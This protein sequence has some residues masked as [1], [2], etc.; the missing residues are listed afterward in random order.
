MSGKRQAEDLD[1]SS[2]AKKQKLSNGATSNGAPT[3][4]KPRPALPAMEAIAKAKRA[5]ELQKQLK[6][7][8][9]AAK[10]KAPTPKPA[11]TQQAAPPAVRP[12]VPL[13]SLQ[14]GFVPY[15]QPRPG[16][17]PTF[18]PAALRLDDQG[19]EIDEFGNLVQNRTESIT[20]LKVN[21]KRPELARMNQEAPA[22]D[23]PD[24]PT[25][26][27]Y[28]DEGIGFR[29]MRKLDRRRRSNFEFVREGQFQKEA[30]IARIRQEFGD[31]GVRQL[32]ARQ[33][34]EKR[35]AAQ[36]TVDANLIP[37]GA[38]RGADAGAAAGPSVPQHAI[39][40]VE[41]WDAR[42]LVHPESYAAP[43]DSERYINEEK[44]TI[45]VE[46]P[47]PLDPPVAEAP[48]PPMPLMLT[49]KEKKKIRKQRRE[50]R[51]KERQDLIR[52][53]LLEAP[54]PKVKLS[55]MMRVLGSEATADPTAVEAQVRQQMEDR[56]Q[57]HEDRNL[58]RKL[59]PA[60]KKEKKLKKLVGEA[61]EGDA[62]QVALYKV[63]DL[64]N[65][66]HQFKVRVNAQELHMTG[67]MLMADDF[68]LVIAE[69]SL[70]SHKKYSRLMLN[71]I[72]W[73][74]SLEDEQQEAKHNSC[75]L[76]WQGVVQQKVFQKFDL[77]ICRTEAAA[78][79]FLKLR[80]LEHYWDLARGHTSE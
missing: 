12:P 21:Q 44:I 19:R 23:K 22:A 50:E 52:Q 15:G 30:E 72:D 51:E 4:A 32:R 61:N 80:G 6:A 75:S 29:G 79:T 45:Y 76:V 64:S 8:L 35:A 34:E 49:A 10:L 18:R 25:T 5:L 59:T 65:R 68:C 31:E 67:C 69:G 58:A 54:K 38:R 41:W 13:H 3:S 77:E 36:A 71:R 55:N 9:E 26:E 20:T 70:K 2:P 56:A 24:R 16:P 47:V 17:K 57:A 27:E 39:P 53:G 62:P 66:Q 78:K 7:K 42:I 60:E 40:E 33:Q 43:A 37:L 48:A 73:N 46:H 63:Q 28:F 74:Q 14:P 1:D 11:P